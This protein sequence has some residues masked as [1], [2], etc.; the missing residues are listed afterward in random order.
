LQR[1]QLTR[2]GAPIQVPI[3]AVMCSNNGDVLREA[4][5]AGQGIALLPTFLVG[6][7]IKAHRLAVVLPAYPPSALGIHALY[8]PNRYL[9]AKTRLLID[10]LAARFGHLSAWDDFP[11][12]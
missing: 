11:Q 12:E 9:A 4:A 2:D 3:Q 7:D 1:W 10:F 8:A 5:L 6:P